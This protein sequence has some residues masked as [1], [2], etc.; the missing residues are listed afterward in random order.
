MDILFV[1]GL[2]DDNRINLVLDGKGGFQHIV[3]GSCN[4][5]TQIASKRFNSHHFSLAGAGGEQNYSFN[6]KPSVIFNEISDADTHNLSLQRCAQFYCQQKVPVIN[7][8]EAIANTRRDKVYETLCH[9]P[10]VVIPKT[11]RFRPHSPDDIKDLIIEHFET[12]VLLREAGFHGGE[13]LIKI[14]GLNDVEKA[15]YV[16]PLDGRA[17]YLSEFKDY[18]DYDGYYRKC[19]LA[20]VEGTPY[21]RHFLIGDRWMIHSS[22]RDFMDK[23]QAL[24]DEERQYILHFY[25]NIQP[26][27]AP[28]TQEI[29][30]RLELDYFGIDCNLS[31]DQMLIFEANAN[32]NILI[33]THP[34][35]EILGT[36]IKTIQEHVESMI[37]KKADRG[38][39][40]GFGGKPI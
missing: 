5:S 30:K 38:G 15:T 28:L 18:R 34:Y 7:S 29:A 10:G 8:P 31:N 26:K 36:S 19:R 17:F 37:Y 21:I 16:S 2:P 35:I 4:V 6:F 13:T 33:N 24:L 27:L 11:I 32:M 39:Q 3:S 1:N 20:V 23:R 14:D 40:G 9:I 12:P 25:R 22:T